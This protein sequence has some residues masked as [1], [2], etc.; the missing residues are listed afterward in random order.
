MPPSDSPQ[1]HRAPIGVDDADN[2]Q[3]GIKQ[4][5][6]AD[7]ASESGDTPY[8]SVMACCQ[9]ISPIRVQSEQL[10]A[11]RIGI[12]Q[13]VLDVGGQRSPPEA[14]GH[15]VRVKDVEMLFPLHF[16]GRGI[17]ADDALAGQKFFFRTGTPGLSPKAP[18]M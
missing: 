12:D 2:H 13:V 5:T 17:E 3:S 18:V 6:A 9:A 14:I 7:A 4:G 10:P 1:E 16:A 8:S 11:G 15:N